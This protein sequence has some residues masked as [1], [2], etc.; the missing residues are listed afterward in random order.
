MAQKIN[1]T[2]FR[3]G[4]TQLWNSN[5]QVYDKTFSF[6]TYILHEHLKVYSVLSKLFFLNGFLLNY[7]EWKFDKSK[8][9]INIFYSVVP[10]NDK[11]SKSL[12][13][14]KLPRMVNFW[15]FHN[16]Y[17]HLYLKSS[18]SLSNNLLTAYSCH[19]LDK[20]VSFKKTIWSLTKF[21]ETYLNSKKLSYYK[22]G[23]LKL[24]LEGFK[25]KISGRLDNSKNQ[26]AKSFEQSMGYLPLTSL[27]SY[28]V[29][30]N[31]K[32]YTKSGVCGLKVWLYYKICN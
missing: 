6:Y 4:I 30:S 24:K 31:K 15:F 12:F 14:Q 11:D 25:I 28:V 17:T 9:K 21:L 23:V 1:P 18:W 32:I 13:F 5:F 7:Q 10:F 27:K 20:H 19:L 8:V 16:V 3:L 2:S 26:M 22:C 29:F